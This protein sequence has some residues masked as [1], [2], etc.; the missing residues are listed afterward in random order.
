M[1]DENR[2]VG[3]RI[4]GEIRQAHVEMAALREELADTSRR[5]EEHLTINSAATNP[6]TKSPQTSNSESSNELSHS[7]G[8]TLTSVTSNSSGDL[9]LG[10]KTKDCSGSPLK[11]KLD[12]LSS[13]KHSVGKIEETDFSVSSQINCELSDSVSL[14]SKKLDIEL[15]LCEEIL[16]GNS[17]LEAEEAVNGD[18]T[19]RKSEV[20]NGDLK[21]LIRPPSPIAGPSTKS[22]FGKYTF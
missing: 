15:D 16:G 2:T 12:G 14:G 8:H 1:V 11:I 19:E 22:D 9:G 7:T 3:T 17:S 13:P 6:T 10:T 20:S 5:L 4:D 18:N 21:Q